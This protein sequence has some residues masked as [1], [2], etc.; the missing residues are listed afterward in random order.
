V[1]HDTVQT[2]TV[3][4][5]DN[6]SQ[7]A[8]H[9]AFVKLASKKNGGKWVSETICGS[10]GVTSDNHLTFTTS[11]DWKDFVVGNLWVVARTPACAEP[12]C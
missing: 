11:T 12:R 1:V 10:M 2:L 3:T 9:D 7:A 6:P 4:I 5:R 8:V